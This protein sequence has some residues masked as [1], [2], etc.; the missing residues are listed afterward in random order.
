LRTNTEIL[1][2]I[3]DLLNDVSSAISIAQS[4]GQSGSPDCCWLQGEAESLLKVRDFMFSDEVV[5][6][7]I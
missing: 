4:Y 2:F 5:N 3:E 1:E 6:E 7:E